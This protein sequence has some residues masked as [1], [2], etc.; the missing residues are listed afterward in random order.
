MSVAYS[1]KYVLV[2]FMVVL[3]KSIL[4]SERPADLINIELGV[5]ASAEGVHRRVLRDL[6]D[7]ELTRRYV[8][9]RQLGD[10]RLRHARGRERQR[11]ATDDARFPVA[12]GVLDCHD[13]PL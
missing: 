9:H 13:H 11:A 7:Y 2:T 5:G 12:R 1:M 3:Q 10:D 8:D 4:W 6:A